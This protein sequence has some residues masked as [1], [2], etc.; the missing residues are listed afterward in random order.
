MFD[1]KKCKEIVRRIGRP[2]KRWTK[3]SLKLEMEH[4]V[5]MARRLVR[6]PY[7]GLSNL[8]M[9][10]PII[11]EHIQETASPLPLARS[12]LR[13]VAR[14]NER[15]NFYQDARKLRE[16]CGSAGV[17]QRTAQALLTFLDERSHA[18]S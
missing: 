12:L 15:Q 14:P 9:D 4:H 8:I 17:W 13:W 2:I 10:R 18:P 3:H 1:L 6:T 7:I 11:R 16:L 5:W